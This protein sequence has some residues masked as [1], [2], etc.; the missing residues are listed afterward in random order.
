MPRVLKRL[1]RCVYRPKWTLG[2]YDVITFDDL[3]AGLTWVPIKGNTCEVNVS[4]LRSLGDYYRLIR[5]RENG[6]IVYFKR[7]HTDDK[8][9]PAEAIDAE[10]KPRSNVRYR[11]GSQCWLIVNTRWYLVEVTERWTGH[12]VI[13]TSTGRDAEGVSPWPYDDV[14]EFKMSSGLRR[15]LRPLNARQL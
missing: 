10:P 7:R 13:R 14:L 15:F 11:V 4:V 1:K 9:T 2:E 3:P 8:V 12:M 6:E 5:D